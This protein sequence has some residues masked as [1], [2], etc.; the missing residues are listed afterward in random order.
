MM[1]FCTSVHVGSGYLFAVVGSILHT[2]Q[3][4]IGP[5]IQISVFSANMAIPSI[6]WL[7]LTSEHGFGVDAQVDTVCIF[8][9]VVATIL[10]RVTGCANL[11][12]NVRALKKC[13][14]AFKPQA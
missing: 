7:A 8:I 9:A 1:A 5:S 3:V 13:K 11:K 4:S 2:Q 6:P 14:L 10:A 12:R